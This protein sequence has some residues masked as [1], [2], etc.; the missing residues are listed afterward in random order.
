MNDMLARLEQAQARQRRFVADASHELRSPLTRMRTELEVDLQHPTT[1]DPAATQGSVLEEVIGLQ[2]LVDDLL[3]LARSDSEP[4][5]VVAAASTA[6]G[7]VVAEAVQRTRWPD[8]L[9]LDVAIGDSAMV[10]G[11]AGELERAIGNLLDNAIRH[12]TTTVHIRVVTDDGSVS[13]GVEDDGPGIPAGDAERVFERFARLDAARSLDDGGA[14]LGLSIA[15]D[16]V[17]RHGGTLVV[18]SSVERGAR[19]V[20]TLPSE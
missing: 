5:T 15:R 13:I 7:D 4:T 18:D 12:A 14:G 16:I 20:I 1:A 3:V 17:E 11:R 6:I 2:Q 10:T 9:A 19:L 8:G